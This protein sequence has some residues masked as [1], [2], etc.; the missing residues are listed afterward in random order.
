M[1]NIPQYRNR[2][3]GLDTRPIMRAADA[4]ADTARATAST[5]NLLGRQFAEAAGA[6]G[7]AVTTWE[8]ERERVRATDEISQGAAVGAAL[9]ATLSQERNELI[10]TTDPNLLPAALEKFYAERVETSIGEYQQKFSTKQGQEYASQLSNRIRQHSFEV[11]AGAISTAK[12]A[13]IR[14]N[15]ETLKNQASFAALA[16]PTSVN[17]QL[18]M[19]DSTIDGL[20][21][22]NARWITPEQKSSLLA[23]ASKMKR[24]VVLAAGTGMADI[25][26][27]AAMADYYKMPVFQQYTDAGDVSALE[28][29]ARVRQGDRQQDMAARQRAVEKQQ[30]D[31]VNAELVKLEA[32]SIDA[33]GNIVVPPN[34]AE[35]FTNITRMPG[36]EVGE[37]RAMKNGYVA[38]LKDQIDG[39][40]RVSDPLQYEALRRNLDAGTLTKEQVYRARA[41]N[42]LSNTDTSMFS[43]AADALSRD[44]PAGRQNEKLF[45]EFLDGNKRF[46]TES[47]PIKGTFDQGGDRRF[48]EFSQD[49]RVRYAQGLAAGKNPYDLLSP[50]SPDYVA[51]DIGRYQINRDE[52]RQNMSASRK[53]GGAPLPPEPVP[54]VS[55]PGAV[56]VQDRT[57]R[58][59]ESADDFFKRIGG[60]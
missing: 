49:M 4:T 6:V 9:N 59:G 20:V 36:A 10:N 15:I 16:D 57:R 13:A 25:N 45:N 32:D 40:M 58:A 19:I 53:A 30:K 48:L 46:V 56:P 50:R 60:N 44:D 21:S 39:T 54:G 42:L 11:G 38:I 34:F 33:N 18:S 51:R 2:I 28:R 17:L 27:E 22:S 14:Q 52:W 55:Q 31:E 35:R 5:Y 7:D 37:I 29:Y 23:E 41:A 8:E 24:E 1:P 43:Q 3:D 26:P 12:G 47:N